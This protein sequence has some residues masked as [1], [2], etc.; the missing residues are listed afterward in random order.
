MDGKENIIHKEWRS[1][2]I[3]IINYKQKGIGSSFTKIHSITCCIYLITN[4]TGVTAAV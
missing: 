2:I 4:F 3:D 1:V